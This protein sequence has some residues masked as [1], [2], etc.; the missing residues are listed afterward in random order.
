MQNVHSVA[1]RVTAYRTVYEHNP[2]VSINKVILD[3]A[4]NHFRAMIDTYWTY[5]HGLLSDFHTCIKYMCIIY[6]YGN[7]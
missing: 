7:R 6:K 1:L 4:N 5:D 2:H 3:D